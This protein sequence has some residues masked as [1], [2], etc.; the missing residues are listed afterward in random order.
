MSA[1]IFDAACGGS[2]KVSYTLLQ[3]FIVVPLPYSPLVKDS[4]GKGGKTT[5]EWK[6]MYDAMVV[7]V[8]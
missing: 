2:W 6:G 3:L 8:V 7:E 4:I 1:R 5:A